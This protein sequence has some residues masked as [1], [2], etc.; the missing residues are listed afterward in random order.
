VRGRSGDGSATFPEV[1][2]DVVVLEQQVDHFADDEADDQCDHDS[3]DVWPS[4]TGQSDRPDHP[5]FD[6]VVG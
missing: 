2:P 1:P 3:S 4:C 6:G 5:V